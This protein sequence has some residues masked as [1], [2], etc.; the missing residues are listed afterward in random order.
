MTDDEKQQLLRT[1][2]FFSGCTDRELHDIASLSDER[3]LEP[4]ADLCHQG[5][6][7]SEVYVIVDG[8][9]EILID[10]RQVAT[11]GRGHIVGELSMLGS[12]RRSATVRAATT[13]LVL[14]IDPRE[15]D[16]VLAADP[17]SARRLSDHESGS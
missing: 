7:E 13:L 14:A 4:G 5:E 12:G 11:E 2:R 15:I 6:F 17:S 16:S 1:I 3:T 9:A 8:T 10:G